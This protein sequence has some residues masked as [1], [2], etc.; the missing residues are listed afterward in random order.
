MKNPK[1]SIIV[2]VYNVEKYL[3]RCIDSILVQT[4]TNFECILVND[5]SPD[6]CP[7]ICDEYSGKDSRVK[8]IHK[9]QNEGLPLARKSGFKNSRG[10]YI[11]FV[12][13][14]DW[15][16]PN[17][18]EK[19]YSA[20]EKSCADIAVCD[21]YHYKSHGYIYRNI[22]VDTE[23]NLNNLG[24]ISWNDSLCNKI[25]RREILAK[26]EFPR[27][28]VWEDVAISQQIYFFSE[29]IVKVPY[30][31]YHYT[32]NPDSL[33]KKDNINKYFDTQKNML[34]V[35]SFFKKNL[36]N[37]FVLLE[38][39]INKSVNHFKLEVLKNKILRREKKLYLFYPESK[40]WRY[41]FIKIIKMLF[42]YIITKKL[43][44]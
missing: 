33:L 10:E 18:T 34:F 9:I 17:M 35:I 13:S 8:V 28:N 25:F 14:D 5:C 27:A 36:K 29:K 21:F 32:F 6:N 24:F 37:K 26:V 22:S 11:Q 38:D 23:N 2:P 4:L 39:N 44:K 3:H 40:F 19:L 7:K 20:A 41:L 43:K 15:I 16:E 42:P 12:D 30:P 31:L 1:V